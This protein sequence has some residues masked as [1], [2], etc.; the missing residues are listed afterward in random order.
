LD[1]NV[2][3]NTL[4]HFTSTRQSL[5]GIL[6]NGLFA[7]YS[8]ENFESI[9][10]DKAELVFP[11][12]CFCDI[13][14]SQ[15]KRHTSIYGKY[16][17]GFTK[18]WGMKNKINPVIYTY[19]NST[20]ADILNELISELE[21]FFDIDEKEKTKIKKRRKAKISFDMDKILN[22][23][24][25]KYKLE[26]GEKIAEL[27]EKLGHFIKYI[28]PY[29][30]KFF[31]GTD[32]LENHVKFYEEREWRYIPNRAVIKQANLKDSFKAEYYKD[33]IKRRAINMKLAKHAKLNFNANDIRFIVVNK[34][35]EIPS[36]LDELEKIFRDKTPFKDLKLL[37]TRLISLQQIID[38]L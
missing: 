13:P 17:I 3:A 20:T 34:D 12:T 31:R 28:K 36:T 37:G 5:L 10:S 11:M 8:L 32:Y 35:S 26:V 2:S 9:I 24:S 4:F 7:R 22:D 6:S 16:A 21:K 14:L 23:H 15:V 1:I 19:P 33:A 27:H 29:E 25:F 30:G 18:N 38:D